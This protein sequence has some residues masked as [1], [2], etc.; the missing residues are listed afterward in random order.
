MLIHTES[1]VDTLKI[2]DLT[3]LKDNREARSTDTFSFALQERERESMRAKIRYKVL[4][5][6]KGETRRYDTNHPESLMPELDRQMHKKVEVQGNLF[7]ENVLE[8]KT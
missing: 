1:I 7:F 2:K 8:E 3:S 6:P 5:Y 4:P